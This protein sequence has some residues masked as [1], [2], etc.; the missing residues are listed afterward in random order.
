VLLSVADL[1]ASL[2]ASGLP[3]SSEIFKAEFSTGPIE[4]AEI[5][6]DKD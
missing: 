6:E 1:D 5:V 3:P 2:I 4:E